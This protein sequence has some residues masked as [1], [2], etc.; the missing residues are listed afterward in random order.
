[1]P[2]IHCCSSSCSA[3]RTSITTTFSTFGT[4]AAIADR[5]ECVHSHSLT[6]SFNVQRVHR[7][8]VGS[9]SRL[10][11]GQA[12]AYVNTTQHEASAGICSSPDMRCVVMFNAYDLDK[13]GTLSRQEI[14]LMLKSSSSSQKHLS[15]TEVLTRT[16][17]TI[18]NNARLGG[19][20]A[21]PLLALS[22]AHSCSLLS[23]K[24]SRK[25]TSITTTSSLWKSSFVVTR[26]AYV[27]NARRL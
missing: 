24:S 2:R 19:I 18:L 15:D 8:L 21:S 5:L 1:V 26:K 10:G 20:N 14:L 4:P 11:G 12:V 22:H 6:H 9:H 13:S 16:P 7:V 23:S 27:D 25:S 17:T 3:P